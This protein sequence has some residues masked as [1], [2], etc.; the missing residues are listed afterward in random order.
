IELLIIP[1]YIFVEPN[2][3]LEFV[4]E[5]KEPGVQ[6]MVRFAD[7]REVQSDPRFTIRRPSPQRIVVQS[8]VG[9]SELEDNTRIICYTATGSHQELLVQ[10]DTGCP[11]DHQRC[12][13][14]TCRPRSD[15]C[16]GRRDCP[17]G[18][19]EDPTRC[20]LL[21]L[22]FSRLVVGSFEVSV[23]PGAINVRP[24]RRFV[25]E[26]TSPRPGVQPQV[27]F[28]GFP[29]ERNRLFV[30]HRPSAERVIVR[31]EQG[32]PSTGIH[33]F[34]YVGSLIRSMWYLLV[35]DDDFV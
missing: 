7:G 22:L 30:V 12:R 33:I 1:G 10:V 17:D 16:N 29:A 23:T 8:E 35:L 27:N 4:C 9:L 11:P 25:F 20:E 24:H 15:F 3:P 21:T 5:S 13:D 32:L 28:D 6:P 31:A 14:G 18:S 2:A 26:C 19:D 34:R